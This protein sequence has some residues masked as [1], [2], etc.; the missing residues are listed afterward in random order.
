MRRFERDEEASENRPQS[1][2]LVAF[3]KVL[4]DALV[5]KDDECVSV[6]GELI[7]AS[8]RLQ[9]E[10]A[11]NAMYNYYWADDGDA[12]ADTYFGKLVFFMV[13]TMV[14]NRNDSLDDEDVEYF[15]RLRGLLGPDW[16]RRRRLEQLE[17]KEDSSDAELDELESLQ[18]QDAKSRVWWEAL[19]DRAERCIANWCIANP[20]LIDRQGHATEESGI[21]DLTDMLEPSTGSRDA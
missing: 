3:T 18:E 13:D 7:R 15:S 4:W 21:R 11:S 1:E 9:H 5:P 6:Q 19:F 14:A 10:Y 2:R 17:S 16:V 20:L 12:L 8:G